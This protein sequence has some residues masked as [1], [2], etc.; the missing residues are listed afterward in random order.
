MNMGSLDLSWGAFTLALDDVLKLDLDND[1]SID[2]IFYNYAN[3]SSSAGQAYASGSSLGAYGGMA[4]GAADFYANQF[5]RV[6]SIGPKFSRSFVSPRPSYYTYT[7]E[8]S[9]FYLRDGFVGRP[10]SDWG[11]YGDDANNGPGFLGV[12]FDI[13]G[14]SHYGFV[15]LEIDLSVLNSG[16]NPANVPKI[17]SYGYEDVA[18]VHISGPGN[19]DFDRDLDVDDADFLQWQR[20]VGNP[21]ALQRDGNANRDMAVDGQDLEIWA[22]QFGQN[23]APNVNGAAVPEPNALGLL[24]LGAAGLAALRR[25]RQAQDKNA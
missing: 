1:S 6:S 23:L 2:V 20:E 11:S 10:L 9:Y 17:L 7:I 12:R 3:S 21:D 14:T 22:N 15:E 8:D 4:I 18:D 19:A 13:D 24:A 5:S 25:R 16:G